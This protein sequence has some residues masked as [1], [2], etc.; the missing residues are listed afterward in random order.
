MKK[1][2]LS[3]LALIA[4]QQYAFT[5]VDRCGTNQRMNELMQ[6][7]PQLINRINAQEASIQQILN[8]N[9]N[10]RAGSVITIPVVFHVLY[11]NTTQNIPDTRIFEQLNVMNNDFART[12]ADAVNTNPVFAGVASATQI[13]FCLAKRT[14]AGAATTG[15]VRVPIPGAFP[16]NPHSVSPEW[17]HTRYLN[18]YIGDLGGLLGYANYP[19]GSTGNDHAVLT[20][21]AVGG[22]NDPGTFNPYHLGRTATHEI[23]HWLNLAHTFD[24]GCGGTTANNCISGGDKVCDTPPTAANNFGC[25]PSSQNTCTET[26]P[27]PPPYTSNMVDMTQNY[28]DYSNDACMNLFTAGQ[29]ARMNAAITASRSLLATSMGCVPLS[30]E[31][32]LSS[33]FA[34]VSPNPS[35]GNFDLKLY[36][37]QSLDI[38]ILV[39]DIAGKV[40]HRQHISVTHPV[41]LPLNLLHLSKGIYLLKIETDKGSLVKRLVI[42]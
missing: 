29:A 36:F 18:I 42:E 34:S 1:L 14:P 41:T 21:D 22:P 23:G 2:L 4:T 13:Q 28:M 38:N 17:D 3:L 9:A 11:A 25:P 12:N 6:K 27:F 39:I 5:Q 32:V 24:N 37:E 8:T 7:D 33:S 10:Y 20:F 26:S 19:P 35:N 16:G 15:I 31:E 40:L 30:V